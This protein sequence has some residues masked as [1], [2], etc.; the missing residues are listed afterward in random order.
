MVL[1]AAY[2][3]LDRWVTTNVPPAATNA[4]RTSGAPDA[5]VHTIERDAHGNALGGIRLPAMAV[6]TATNAGDNQPGNANPQNGVCVFL[7]SH[8][9][10]DAALVRSLYPDRPVYLREVRRVVEDLVA[11][12]VVLKED[13]P[14][15]MKRAEEALPKN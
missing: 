12:Y 9:P 11:Q 8:T 7:G 3:A 13:A 14:T 6:P 15:L 2:A 1:T 4:I 5:P 10:F